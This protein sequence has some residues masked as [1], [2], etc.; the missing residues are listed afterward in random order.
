M[1]ADGL[2]VDFHKTEGLICKRSTVD[3]YMAGL[4]LARWD[5]GR[6]I[7]SGRPPWIGAE[8]AALVAARGCRRRAK[9]RRIAG[10]SRKRDS[11][12]VWL[13]F[14]VEEHAPD[15][16]NTTAGLARGA[17][18]AWSG[19]SGGAAARRS[20]EH[21]RT[22]QSQREEG[23]GSKRIPTSTR[24]SGRARIREGSDETAVRRRL[25]APSSTMARLWLGLGFWRAE[26]GG[27]VDGG[28]GGT[29]GAF[30]RLG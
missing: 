2:R 23:N 19:R 25:R 7:G 21:L 28:Q 4:T 12:R 30:Y 11:G 3:R 8:R 18:M 27:G 5:L 10:V 1:N 22:E 15:A 26:K 17:D 29:G 9:R 16:V 20:V 14:W 13:G 24:N 6:W